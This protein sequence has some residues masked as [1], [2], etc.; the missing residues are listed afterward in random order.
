MLSDLEGDDGKMRKS[1]RLVFW[2]M[3]PNLFRG[4]SSSDSTIRFSWDKMRRRTWWSD[5]SSTSSPFDPLP[6]FLPFC[7]GTSY[8]SY[9]SLILH[10]VNIE[11][12]SLIIR[13]RL[14][15]LL[16]L[17]HECISCSCC[18]I[19]TDGVV[20]VA[21]VEQVIYD[22]LEVSSSRGNQQTLLN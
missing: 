19:R 20:V 6:Q 16:Y 13:S 12:S 18:N 15:F 22:W 2:W 17:F 1:K 4:V 3:D 11:E 10:Q 21:G 14:W 5:H 9:P 8:S 7:P